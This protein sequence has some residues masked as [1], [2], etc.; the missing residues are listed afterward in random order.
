[1]LNLKKLRFKEAIQDARK[2][3]EQVASDIGMLLERES[4]VRAPV[5]KTGHLRRSTGSDVDHQDNQSDIIVGTNNVEYAE[6]VH[7]GSVARNITAQPYIR[8]SIE[9]NM[10]TM[11]QMI[12]KGM[13]P[14]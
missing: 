6:V 10:S 7:E 14:K 4:K 2:Q 3:R 11:Q 1:M 5:G 8:D 13:K 9:A 12:A